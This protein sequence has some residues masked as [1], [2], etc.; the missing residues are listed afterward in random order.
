MHTIDT[1]TVA[2]SEQLFAKKNLQKKYYLYD[3]G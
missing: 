3:I 2:N 1:Y